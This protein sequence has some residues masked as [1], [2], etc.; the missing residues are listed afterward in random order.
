MHCGVQMHWRALALIR[1]ASPGP[2]KT[3]DVVCLWSPY[4]RILTHTDVG[5][6]S[7]APLVDVCFGVQKAFLMSGKPVK[8]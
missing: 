5:S 4:W 7:P 6:S 8:A 3:P 2:C 1:K